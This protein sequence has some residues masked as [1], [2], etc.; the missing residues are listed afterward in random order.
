MAGYHGNYQKIGCVK[1]HAILVMSFLLCNIE[2]HVLYQI[3][4]VLLGYLLPVLE[5]PET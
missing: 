3:T 2:R 4:A 5:G 1:I